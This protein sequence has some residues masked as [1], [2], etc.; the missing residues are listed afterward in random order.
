MTMYVQKYAY[1]LHTPISIAIYLPLFVLIV[2]ASFPSFTQTA[3]WWHPQPSPLR[4]R[5]HWLIFY[6]LPTGYVLIS[7]FGRTR[8]RDVFAGE[9]M[10]SLTKI[11]LDIVV[12][13][14]YAYR[15]VE[16]ART[17][18]SGLGREGFTA[19]APNSRS[20][21]FGC[22]DS[23]ISSNTRLFCRVHHCG[24]WTC[25]ITHKRRECVS[26]VPLLRFSLSLSLSR[27][28]LPTIP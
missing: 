15:T 23:A 7:P 26:S 9:V 2:A 6:P 12:G 19:F 8:F 13:H 17:D 25:S 22:R 1:Y 24:R 10:T 3:S 21:A 11:V 4:F 18:A 20:S 16:N 5:H 28:C 27:V 14:T